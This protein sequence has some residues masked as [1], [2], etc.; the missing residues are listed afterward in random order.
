MPSSSPTA[1]P[2]ANALSGYDVHPLIDTVLHYLCSGEAPGFSHTGD[3]R[4][5]PA[6]PH[7]QT[8]HDRMSKI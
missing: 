4:S 2:Y 3:E 6:V 8:H 1:A 7:P 5:M